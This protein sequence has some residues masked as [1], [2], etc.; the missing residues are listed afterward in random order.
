MK[1]NMG[2]L[3]RAVRIAAGLG[4]VILAMTGTIGA[5][6]YI[7]LV[8]LATSAISFCPLYRVVNFSTRGD[9]A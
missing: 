9:K 1:A 6:G 3:D 8:L 2:M 5:W 7:G 4:L